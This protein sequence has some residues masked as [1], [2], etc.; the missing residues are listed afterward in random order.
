[1]IFA[2]ATLGKGQ[3]IRAYCQVAEMGADDSL[4]AYPHGLSP[5]CAIAQPDAKQIPA[6]ISPKVLMT[7]TPLQHLYARANSL[8]RRCIL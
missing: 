3:K 1:M 7:K 8:N 2:D 4:P 5:D 6:P